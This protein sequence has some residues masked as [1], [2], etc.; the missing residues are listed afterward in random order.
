MKNSTRFR[1]FIKHYWQQRNKYRRNNSNDM[2]VQNKS[3]N[4]KQTLV[5]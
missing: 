2:Y 4:M 5:P 1:N 3:Q